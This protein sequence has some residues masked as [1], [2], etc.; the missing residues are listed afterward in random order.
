MTVIQRQLLTMLCNS[1]DLVPR[2]VMENQFGAGFF[3]YAAWIHRNL[4]TGIID[5]IIGDNGTVVSY[6][7]FPGR[8]HEVCTMQD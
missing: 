1:A 8:R 4:G 7:I 5:R 6:R 3:R 2:A